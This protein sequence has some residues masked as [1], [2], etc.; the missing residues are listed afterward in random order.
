MKKHR[1]VE[2][3]EGPGFRVK[4]P[5]GVLSEDFYNI[6]WAKEHVR[7][8]TETDRRSQFK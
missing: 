7:R 4:Y 8:L 2:N 6:T 1:V 5:D 3:Q